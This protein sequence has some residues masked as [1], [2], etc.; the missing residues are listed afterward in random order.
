MNDHHH[1]RHDACHRPEDPLA[2]RRATNANTLRRDAPIGSKYLL[3]AR[4]EGVVSELRRRWPAE[5][6]DQLVELLRVFTHQPALLDDVLAEVRHWLP[7]L[8]T[9]PQTTHPSRSN[10][11]GSDDDGESA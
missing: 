6:L 8:L 2:H 11:C 7:R 5:R 9:P 3:N 4:I 1:D 10:H